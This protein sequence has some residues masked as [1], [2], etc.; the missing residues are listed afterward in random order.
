MTVTGN[1]QSFWRKKK[2]SL[3]A[4]LISLAGKPCFSLQMYD[5]DAVIWGWDLLLI[6]KAFRSAE[7]HFC[8]ANNWILSCKFT[9][10]SGRKDATICS[11]LPAL[12][13]RR[14][15]LPHSTLHSFKWWWT[16]KGIRSEKQPKLP[17]NVGCFA[18]F[19]HKISHA[20]WTS[21]W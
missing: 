2:L 9:L 11:F 4:Q 18:H 14:K 19:G 16:Q 13:F 10:K 7:T 17:L 1:R 15:A 20:V 6:R 5:I 3:A 21:L 12:N 8:I